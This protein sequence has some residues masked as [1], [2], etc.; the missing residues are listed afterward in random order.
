M[1]KFPILYSNLRVIPLLLVNIYTSK[2]QR[3]FPVDGATVAPRSPCA[4]QCGACVNVRS[5]FA[6]TGIVTFVANKG[7][8]SHHLAAHLCQPHRTTDNLLRISPCHFQLL[9]TLPTKN[10]NT[11]ISWWTTSL[12]PIWKLSATL[13]TLSIRTTEHICMERSKKM[14]NGKILSDYRHFT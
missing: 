9:W 4:S 7:H 13:D 14:E 10:F 2:K 11:R 12:R 8:L 5:D 6:P 1:N 3:K